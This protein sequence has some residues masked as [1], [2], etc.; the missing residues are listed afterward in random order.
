MPSDSPEQCASMVASQ[1]GQ[2]SSYPLHARVLHCAVH[3]VVVGGTRVLLAKLSGRLQ[4]P[5]GLD[6]AC[7]L[8]SRMWRVACTAYSIATGSRSSNDRQQT[9]PTHIAVADVTAM[10]SLVGS[11]SLHQRA[12][13][14]FKLCVSCC[15]RA[16][17]CYGV[18]CCASNHRSHEVVHCTHGYTSHALHASHHGCAVQ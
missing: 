12:R 2:E 4:K 17:L 8:A 7:T 1:R 3:H 14:V 13:T 11:G 10:L 9:V 6:I 16:V 5:H 15:A 18:L